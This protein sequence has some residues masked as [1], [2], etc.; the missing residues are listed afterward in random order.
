MDKRAFQ[1]GYM[2]KEALEPEEAGPDMGL[3]T[4]SIAD[5]IMGVGVARGINK[6]QDR[7]DAQRAGMFSVR[8]QAETKKGNQ[9]WI[10]NIPMSKLKVQAKARAKRARKLALQYGAEGF[11]RRS[12]PIREEGVTYSKPQLQTI[13]EAGQLSPKLWS[14]P[15][16]P[17]A[18]HDA[19]FGVHRD[20]LDDKKRRQDNLEEYESKY[21]PT[22]QKR[23]R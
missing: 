7:R 13:E 10:P 17:G 16:V 20:S 4:N 11:G 6:Y 2:H 18:L 8:R 21:P 3:K 15:K 5:M 9:P 12:Q 22:F 1:E 19:T 14:P 23:V